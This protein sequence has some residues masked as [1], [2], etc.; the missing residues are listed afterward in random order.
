MPNIWIK[1]NGK[2]YG[3]YE[4]IDDNTDLK[5]LIEL[6][7]GREVGNLVQKLINDADYTEKRVTTDLNAYEEQLHGYTLMCIEN[8]ELLEKL[9][10]Q[11][12]G[13]KRVDRKE[14]VKDLE[15]IQNLIKNVG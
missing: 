8:L 10:T 13:V 15:V 6:Y 12:S 11:L 4:M 5:I 1:K 2:E 14:I 7:L 9:I 3:E